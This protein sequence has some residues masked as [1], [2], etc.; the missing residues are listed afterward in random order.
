MSC[1]VFQAQLAV[2]LRRRRVDPAWA[3]AVS[4][5]PEY[6]DH[7]YFALHVTHPNGVIGHVGYAS[8]PGRGQPQDGYYRHCFGSHRRPA[9]PGPEH[10]RCPPL[11]QTSCA[12]IADAVALLAQHCAARDDQPADARRCGICRRRRP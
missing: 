2:A 10:A 5:D 8:N 4:P 11:H 1:A 12:S 6:L 9:P 3:D 7:R